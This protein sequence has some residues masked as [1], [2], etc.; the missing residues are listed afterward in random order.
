MRS[1]INIIY[2]VDVF[3]G[4]CLAMVEVTRDGNT[5]NLYQYAG[6]CAVSYPLG[7]VQQSQLF[8]GLL[9]V[10]GGVAA[11]IA[12][13]GVAALAAL[14]VVGGVGAAAQSSIGRSGGFS[15]NAGAM[16]IKKP[17]LILQRPQTKVADTFPELAGYPTNYSCKL[18][19]CSGHVVVK[20]VHIEGVNA[21]DTELEQIDSL[22]KDGVI[23]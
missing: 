20:H 13:G 4:A 22:L 12:S 9:A 5:V 14:A 18:G 6:V 11:S 23:V 16:G 7:N 21:T 15:G 8:A 2:G 1:T 10:A 19:D 3:T 17:Y